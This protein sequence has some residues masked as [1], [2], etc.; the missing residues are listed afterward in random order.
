[1]HHMCPIDHPALPALFDLAVPNSSVL[2]SVIEGRNAGRAWVDCIQTPSQCVIRTDAVY[3]FFSRQ[4][5]QTFLNEAIGYFRQTEPIWLVWSPE[6]TVEPLLFEDTKIS[7]R[8]EF[9]DCD[10]HDPVLADWRRRLPDEFEIRTIDRTLLE[11]CQWRSAMAH[12]C[13]SLD[14]FLVNGTGLCLMDGDDI[15]VEAYAS[16]FGQGQAEI[17]VITHESYRGQGYAPITCAYLIKVCAELGY[18]PYWSCD[19][20]NKASANVARKLGFQQEKVYQ[21]LDYRPLS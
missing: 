12:W 7:H 13:G 19:V 3:T 17:D 16:S 5:S 2:W 20:A 6:E 11:R 4:I 15:V 9:Y 14:N 10:V 21:L 8:L 1:M 18:Q